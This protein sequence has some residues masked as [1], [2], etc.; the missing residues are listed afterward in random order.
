MVL[1][2]SSLNIRCIGPL[3][4]LSIILQNNDNNINIY[5]PVSMLQNKI[6][7]IFLFSERLVL[8]TPHFGAGAQNKQLFG[9]YIQHLGITA[10][11]ENVQGHGR[12]CP[13]WGVNTHVTVYNQTM[14][15]Q[16]QA[17]LP[18]RPIHF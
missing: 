16:W 1:H 17:F 8:V 18:Q 3:L 9:I 6:N 7:N 2:V 11:N 5:I 15:T 13:T 10:T 12:S 14:S 4:P